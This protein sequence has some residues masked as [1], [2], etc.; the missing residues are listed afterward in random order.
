MAQG[1][2][3]ADSRI[4]A[5]LTTISQIEEA[6]ASDPDNPALIELKTIF[7]RRIQALERSTSSAESV[8]CASISDH[9]G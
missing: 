5:L 9:P 2:K 8:F 1:S 4:E 7:L 6:S 3:H